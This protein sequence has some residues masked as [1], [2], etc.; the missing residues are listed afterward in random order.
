MRILLS[1]QGSFIAQALSAIAQSEKIAVL[2][3]P[4]DADLNGVIQANDCVINFAISPDYRCAAYREDQDYDLRAARAAAQAGAHFVMLST[5]KIYCGD[6]KW[7]AREDC[8]QGGGETLYGQNKYITEKKVQQIHAGKAGI[9][10]LSN[11]FGYE[12]NSDKPRSS[13]LGAL[14]TSLKQK[15]TIC[16]DMSSQTNRDF[17]PVDLCV[18]LLLDRIV[19]RT[20]GVFNLGA[21]FAT[22]CGHLADWICE[23]FGGG[24][25]ICDPDEKK[26]EFFLNMEKWGSRFELPVSEQIVRNYCLELGR[27]LK[28]EKY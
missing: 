23:G 18:R 14:L 16:F 1:G 26:D 7:N 12:Y 17:L 28:C 24:A 27:K 4:H 19:D 20:V 5:R 8:D 22:P 21:G 3:L 13:F 10:R 11:I 6:E 2:G 25:V 15:K 9:F